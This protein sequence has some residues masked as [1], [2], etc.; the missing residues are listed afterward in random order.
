[1]KSISLVVAL[2]LAGTTAWS[3]NQQSQSQSQPQ[4]KTAM[5]ELTVRGCLRAGEQTGYVLGNAVIEAGSITGTNLR[6]RV[7]PDNNGIELKPHL[8]HQV[9]LV[10][11]WDGRT[12]PPSGKVVPETEY[13]T[14]RV[15]TL[16]MIS[17][18]CI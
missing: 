9:R 16:S 6:F 12:P 7:V 4:D 15:R 11:P 1:M 2:L 14:L 17:N 13:P 5:S 3:Q 10:G 8:N 18:E